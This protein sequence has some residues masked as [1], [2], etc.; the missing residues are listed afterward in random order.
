MII[1]LSQSIET[2]DISKYLITISSD[3]TYNEWIC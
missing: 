1:W 3:V 2:K